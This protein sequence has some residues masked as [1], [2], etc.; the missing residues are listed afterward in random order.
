MAPKR[1][2]TDKGKGE[3]S[4]KVRKVQAEASAKKRSLKKEQFTIAPFICQLT[5]QCFAP[6]DL[7]CICFERLE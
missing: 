2:G 6:W 5:M 7:N 4:Q 3:A 1:K